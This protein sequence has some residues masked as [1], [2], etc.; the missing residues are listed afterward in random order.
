MIQGEGMNLGAGRMPAQVP[1]PMPAVHWEHAAS[2]PQPA[3]GASIE[4]FGADTVK[5]RH[6]ILEEHRRRTVLHPARPR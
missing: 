3:R 1:V 5:G 2:A 4:V 6:E